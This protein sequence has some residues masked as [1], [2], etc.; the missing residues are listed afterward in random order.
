[1]DTTD[2]DSG[3][4]GIK[5]S[6]VLKE[7]RKLI[8]E[9]RRKAA[10]IRCWQ[11]SE[12]KSDESVETNLVGLALSG[13]GIRSG[14]L[15]LGILKVLFQHRLLNY[16][17]FMSTVSGGGYA[18]GYLSTSV[19]NEEDADASQGG[20][21]A[22]TSDDPRV[23]FQ[24]TP[25]AFAFYRNGMAGAHEDLDQDDLREQ[26]QRES[27][28]MQEFI[29]RGTYLME[30]VGFIN[31]YLLGA[32]LIW[33]LVISGLF[34]SA[35]L[36]AWVFRSLDYPTGADFAASLGFA[37]DVQRAFFPAAVV[38]VIWTALWIPAWIFGRAHRGH[39]ARWLLVLKEAIL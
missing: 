7:E 3:D 22:E 19:L 11:S 12:S 5:Q 2:E 26:E 33:T 25:A 24:V 9:K 29:H 34:A 38:F 31:C 13:G 30:V 8:S 1:M 28:R 21:H 15:N 16:V 35:S 23:A 10:G 37:G 14:A 39:P 4:C 17:D 32:I 18:G 6:V 27:R 20:K 36:G